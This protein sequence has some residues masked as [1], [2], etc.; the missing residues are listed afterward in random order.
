MSVANGALYCP[1]LED[2]NDLLVDD[3][4]VPVNIVRGTHAQLVLFLVL[5]VWTS[6]FGLPVI[7][8][9]V[10]L[11]KRVKRH[12]TFVNLCLAFIMVGM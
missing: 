1:F 7:L 3:L 5:N 11:S 2:T 12:P 4:L 8:V 10:L 6:H 9:I